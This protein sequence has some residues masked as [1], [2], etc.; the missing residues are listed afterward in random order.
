M[1][2]CIQISPDYGQG[3]QK[4]KVLTV[5]QMQNAEENA[6]KLGMSFMRLMENAG[7]SCAKYINDYIKSESGRYRK[8]TILCG[9]GKNAGD[10]LVIARKLK[11]FG[12]DISVIFLFDRLKAQETIEMYT[13]T[14]GLNIKFYKASLHYDE[15][16]FEIESADIIVDA[17]FGIGFAGKLDEATRAIIEAANESKAKIISIDVPS[18]L[19]GDGGEDVFV[20]ADVTLAIAASKPVHLMNIDRIGKIVTVDISIPESCF[21]E[22]AANVIIPTDENIKRVLPQKSKYA[23]K[24]DFGRAVIIAGSLNYQGAAVLSANACVR[25]G[26]GITQLVIPKAAYSAIAAKVTEPILLPV[27]SN[28]DGTFSEMA[29]WEILEAVKRADAILIGC[30]IGDNAETN[31]IVYDV[32]RTAECPMVIDAD[33]INAVAKNINILREAKA[34]IVMTPHPGE[35]SRLTGTRVGTSVAERIMTALR[36]SE[37]YNVVLALKGANTVVASHSLPVFINI[38]GNNGMATGGSGDALAG[39]I[40][41]LLAQ[42]T[43][44][45]DATAAGV[46]IHGLCGDKAA[47]RL[48]RRGLTPTDMVKE[49]PRVFA[50]FE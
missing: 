10:G 45:F 50:N 16:E 33:G 29:K 36:F 41:S 43:K 28:A 2:Q 49:L 21:P 34:P 13:M 39:I 40:V 27:A 20:N 18:G 7:A 25:S 37:E 4:V 44:V 6:V 48:S 31:Q 5:R 24:G 26:A 17:I 9:S 46:Y 1:L 15:V 22:N 19:S 38:T 12:Y 23:H 3:G 11:Q 47:K 35:M 42:S 8:I 14:D 32:I 30:G